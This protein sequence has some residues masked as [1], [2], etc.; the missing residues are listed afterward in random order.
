M[1]TVLQQMLSRYRRAAKWINGYGQ[2]VMWL[3]SFPF[4]HPSMIWVARA[5][6]L[7][8]LAVLAVSAHE[9]AEAVA[10]PYVN[11]FRNDEEIDATL[12]VHIVLQTFTW[13]LFT[14]GMVLGIT[15]N[16]FHVP[17]Q[18]SSLPSLPLR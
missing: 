7:Q 16:R 15:K 4:A 11:P 2:A 17:L 9:H 1:L 10:G 3:P 13:T 18:V 5:L 12:K 6:T 8:A 14:F